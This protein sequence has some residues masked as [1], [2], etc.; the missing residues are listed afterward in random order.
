VKFYHVEHMKRFFQ[1]MVA[2]VL[3]Y[4]QD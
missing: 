4:P 2:D 1:N 3:Y